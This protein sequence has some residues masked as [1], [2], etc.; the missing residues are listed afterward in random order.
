MKKTV[1]KIA[2]FGAIVFGF[3]FTAC[4]MD[5]IGG[6]SGQ[7]ALQTIPEGATGVVAVNI[8][9]L[10]E[11]IDY[12]N[13]RNTPAFKKRVAEA[14][15]NDPLYGA[16]MED[17][18]A[19]GIAIDQKMYMSIGF[20]E[21]SSNEDFSAFVFSLSDANKFEAVVEAESGETIKAQ[22]G[23]KSVQLA[24]QTVL[25]WNDEYAILG[26]SS[27]YVNLDENLARFFKTEGAAS[28][29][30]N[31]DLGKAFSGKHDIN[32]WFSS[33]TIAENPQTSMAAAMAEIDPESLKDNYIHG[34]LDFLDGQIKGEA[35]LMV[36]KALSKDLDK[37]FKDESSTDF[38]D[39]IA[40]DGLQFLMVNALNFKG[41]HELLS[42]RPNSKG[43]I[44]FALREYGL[45]IEDISKT[46]GGDVM[47]A[48]Y[49][50][51]NPL[52]AGGV[53][54]TDIKDEGKLNEFLKI[55]VENNMLEA[56]DD[57]TYKIIAMAYAGQTGGFEV[58][59]NDGIARLLL[60]DD[61]I[62]I[63]GNE[64]ILDKIKDGG[65]SRSERIDKETL[66]LFKNQLF[67]ALFTAT[68]ESLKGFGPTDIEDIKIEDM[69]I[70][71]NRKNLLFDMQLINKSENALKQ[72][73]EAE[74]AEDG[75]Y[76]AAEEI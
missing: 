15:K 35:D 7:D 10:L 38:G 58:T 5:S 46:F 71:A 57:N 53:F 74:D 65:F 76:D 60:H 9:S 30:Q 13:Y 8:P 6:G 37:I 33:N 26:S 28:M 47:F 75:G 43:F 68:P 66:K 18:E 21:N 44:D 56:I 55:A 22:D 14:K 39:Y 45:S 62:F 27:A 42:A 54:S 36:Q 25:G 59:F 24:R 19:A 2:L 52:G 31:K 48:G 41:I 40:N 73:I 51:E 61:K 1:L 17:P 72:I 4:Q 12:E 3:T 67:S 63:T 16:F 29:A 23:F 11:K 20:A 70:Q 32:S 49:N 64:A 69:L 50:K 34:Y